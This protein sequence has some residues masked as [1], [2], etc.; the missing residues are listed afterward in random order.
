MSTLK[1]AILKALSKYTY[2]QVLKESRHALVDQESIR[3]QLINDARFTKFGQT[4][5]FKDIKS[6][7]DF[8]NHVPIQDYEQM[9]LWIKKIIDGEKNV[10]WKGRPLYFAKTS[11]TTSGIKY[12]PISKESI[13][14]QITGARKALFYYIHQTKNYEVLNGKMIF[15]SGSP[16]LENKNNILTGRLSGIVNHHIPFYLKSNQLPSYGTNCIEDWEQKLSNIVSETLSANMSLISG[17][18]P[19]IQMYFDQLIT[20]KNRPIDQIFPNLSVMIQGGVNFEPYKNKLFKSI[21]KEIDIVETYPASEGFIAFSLFGSGNDLLLNTQAGIFYEFIPLADVNK[22]NP[23]RYSLAE[24]KLGE[25]YT[26]IINSNA[27][28]WGYDIGDLIKFTSLNPYKLLV[29]GRSKHFI[30]AFGEHVIGEE[31][32]KTIQ[33]SMRACSMSFIEFTVAPHIATQEEPGSYHEWFIEFDQPYSTSQIDLLAKKM[34]EVLCSLN[35]YYDDLQKGNILSCL[36]ITVVRAHG[37]INY[38]KSL[39][40]LGG[41]NKL[42]RLTNDRNIADGLLPWIEQ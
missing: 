1:V 42:P 40:K 6:Y 2:K 5:H 27:G 28:L 31:V 17:I 11:G 14:T 24:V 36:Q 22:K 19:W 7:Q 35:I 32:E 39:N 8:K 41:Q 33:E 15:L 3:S 34:N 38:M 9:S 25:T 21:G 20:I 26:L 37:F 4:H 13:K 23:Q 29:V 18:P 12:I 16:V 30:S 10:L